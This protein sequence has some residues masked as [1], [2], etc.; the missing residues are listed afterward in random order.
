[1]VTAVR[2]S[3]A[4]KSYERREDVEDEQYLDVLGSPYRNP[5]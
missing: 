2:G 3:Q 1:M 4:K 5:V